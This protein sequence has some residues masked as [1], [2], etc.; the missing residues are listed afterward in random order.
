MKEAECGFQ[1]GCQYGAHDSR[2]QKAIAIAQKG[3]EAVE[4]RPAI[5]RRR[6]QFVRN[7]R[8]DERSETLEIMHGR[9][10]FVAPQ[11][12]AIRCRC[13][14]PQRFLQASE[15]IAK[16]KPLVTLRPRG[17]QQIAI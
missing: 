14:P 13:R 6:F 9:D 17:A 1:A 15:L 8:S 5:A 2:V 11:A 16:L 7:I 10:S 12:L 3:I 4:R